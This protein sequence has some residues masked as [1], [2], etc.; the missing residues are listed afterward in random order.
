MVADGYFPVG[1]FFFWRSSGYV[2]AE[3]DGCAPLAVFFTVAFAVAVEYDVG[4]EFWGFI[5]DVDDCLEVL[6][7]GGAVFFWEEGVEWWEVWALSCYDAGV[8]E[9]V[10]IGGC[11]VESRC[12]VHRLVAEVCAR[13]LVNEEWVRLFPFG[14]IFVAAKQTSLDSREKHD[15]RCHQGYD[16]RSE[17]HDCGRN[18]QLDYVLLTMT[19]G[20]GRCSENP[21]LGGARAFILLS[22]S[23][24]TAIPTFA[25][26]RSNYDGPNVSFKQNDGIYFEIPSLFLAL[27]FQTWL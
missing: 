16:A 21:N 8:C 6:D 3:E 15:S 14:E 24:T 19:V 12:L 18:A 9:V 22:Q 26:S 4:V 2:T 5:G 17:G 23:I 27:L 10:G 11:V 13:V 20:E 7:Y 25:T 1:A